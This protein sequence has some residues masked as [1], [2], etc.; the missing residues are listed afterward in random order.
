MTQIRGYSDAIYDLLLDRM[1]VVLGPRDW[2]CP[3]AG[4]KQEP[5]IAL[6]TPQ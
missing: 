4:G 5:I 2:C 1:S 3:D 6:T